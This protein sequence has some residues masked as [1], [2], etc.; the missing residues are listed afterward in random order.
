MKNLIFIT[1]YK[2]GLKKDGISKK[3]L[4]QIKAF[5]D[6]GV[7]VDFIHRTQSGVKIRIGGKEVYKDGFLLSRLFFLVYCAYI[8]LK[9]N[10]DF[11]YLRNIYLEPAVIFYPIFIALTINAVKIR[12]L[13]IP[14][15]PFDGEVHG[16]LNKIY[17][18]YYNLIRFLFFS[19]YFNIITYMGEFQSNIWGVKSIRLINSVNLN[20]ILPKSQSYNVDV[21]KVIG[22]AGL[23]FWHGYDRLVK[24]LY[25]YK[26][27]GLNPK[28]EF[29]IVGDQEPEFSNLRKLVKKLELD[30]DV[31]FHG[32][33][34]GA[35]LDR[36][37]DNMDIAVDSIGRHRSG[38]DYNC[39][40]KS[41]EYT[42][43][44]IPFIKS[45]KDDSFEGKK[46]V[47]NIEA[48]DEN[49][50]I[51]KINSWFNNLKLE[52]SE[53]RKHAESNFSWKLQMKK[54]LDN[55]NFIER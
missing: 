9:K 48:N 18:V 55:A 42:A 50:D 53:M 32:A 43:R 11:F 21:V 25:D 17:F 26:K 28:Y 16:W 10:Y 41:K 24:G 44:N 5:E 49:V 27:M 37:F 46:F 34:Y 12:V 7:Q 54:V 19:R 23:Q 39:S 8:I 35:E 29:H 2:V 3:L 33:L 6:L 1:T 45:H 15:Y 31:I 52:K 13:E 4:N 51:K 36:L 20:K 40:I 38:L 30:D 22:V 47:F 14:T